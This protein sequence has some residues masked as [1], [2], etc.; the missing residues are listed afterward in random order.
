GRPLATRRV[1]GYAPSASTFRMGAEACCGGRHLAGVLEDT[2]VW[3][4]NRSA[5]EIAA[6]AL[7]GPAGFLAESPV[8][9]PVR[10]AGYWDFD[11]PGP[12]AGTLADRVGGRLG[13]IVGRARL[14]EP[15]GGRPG[16]GGNRGFDVGVANP[17]WLEYLD[18]A[19]P[20]AAAV[21]NR[22]SVVLWQRTRTLRESS[23]F[24]LANSAGFR[25]GFQ[26][27]LPWTDNR[28]YFDTQGCCAA[29]TR[30][31]FNPVPGGHDFTAW[32][33]YA[34][35]KD[36]PDKRVYIDGRLAHQGANAAALTADFVACF[37]G[38][39]DGASPPDAVLDDFAIFQGALSPAQVG[40]LAAGG[41]PD[42]LLPPAPSGPLQG[43][44]SFDQP[45]VPGTFVIEAEDYDFGGGQSVLSASAMPYPNGAYAGLNGVAGVDFH[46]P[47]GNP[48]PV[49]RPADQ[50]PMVAVGDTARPTWSVTQDFKVGWWDAG[51]WLNYTRLL[52]PDRYRIYARASSGGSPI[53][54]SLDRVVAGRGTASQSLER[55]GTFEAPATGGW[56]TFTTVPLL[57][58]AREPVEVDLAGTNTLRFT[59]L[60]NA[61]LDLGYLL[62]VPTR[63]LGPLADLAR[64]VVDLSGNGRHGDPGAPGSARRPTAV[65]GLARLRP[66]PVNNGVP[67]LPVPFEATDPDGDPI[68][69]RVVRLP[70]QGRLLLADTGRT[71]V[72]ASQLLEPGQRLVYQPQRGTALPDSFALN[73]ADPGAETGED[74]FLV[75]T[76]L[77]PVA[78][79]DGDGMPDAFE[80]ARGLDPQVDDRDGDLDGDG[81]GN[82]R[83]FLETRTEPNRADTDGDGLRDGAELAAGTDPL[84]PDTDGDTIRDGR[85]P[86]PLVVDADLDGDG[87][88]D[89]D[90]PD[91][92]GDDL[93][94]VE[95]GVRGTDPRKPDTDGDGY[96]DAFELALG[97]RPLDAA[98][99]PAVFIVAGPAEGAQVVLPVAPA[100]DLSV[101][102]I[103]VAEPPVDVVLPVAPA[104]DLSVGG[105]TLAEP[106][107][108]VV[109]PVA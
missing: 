14:T 27:H 32:H 60:P 10:L 19:I 50:V 73:Y 79:T 5:A 57:N 92:D 54:A 36:G 105:I 85:D 35:I 89:M 51:D 100:G 96:P 108:D 3:S 75:E 61:N 1:G 82:L 107:V 26:A 80:A 53:R 77:D 58:A 87:L 106:P 99:R 13:T 28:I 71:P 20:N 30:L 88:R 98:S 2:L 6:Y 109:L 49:Y 38:A 74:L 94:N 23:S 68:R 18:G 65:R 44:W 81:L 7:S 46:N 21:G 86:A 72:T 69:L 56:D 91:L 95:E 25:R 76:T 4:T 103:T 90:D 17:G 83:E 62:L 8:R 42:E 84:N 66:F 43:W 104:G 101:G 52:P 11:E 67:D 22:M 15:G 45:P 102:G 37:I 59:L 24:Y 34:F 64:G 29:D 39:G 97:S 41:R 70:S 63:S 55:L 78:D 40:A 93:S 9:E 33:H 31:D 47:G 48:S 12:T 16:A